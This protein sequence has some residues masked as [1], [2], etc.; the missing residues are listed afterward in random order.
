MPTIIPYLTVRNAAAA[1]E[2]YKKALGAE[3]ISRMPG[4]DGRRLIH[5]ALKI[6]DSLLFLADEFTDLPI[7]DACQ[8]PPSLGGT[9]VTIHVYSPDV[10]Q[11]I[12]A[13]V[14]AGATVTMP[15]ADMFWGDRYGRFRDPFGHLWSVATPVRK[16]S[17]EEM[18]LAA[19]RAFAGT[20]GKS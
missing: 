16:M 8:S 17:P 13:A 11:T 19:Q 3:E 7:P 18:K 5:A 1:I 9:A 14:A 4:P 20:P 10:D 6:G 15:V 12:A 2:F